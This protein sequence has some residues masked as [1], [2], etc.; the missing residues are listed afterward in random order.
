VFPALRTAVVASDGVDQTIPNCSLTRDFHPSSNKQSH[1]RQGPPLAGLVLYAPANCSLTR[2]FGTPFL[3][4][5]PSA[6]R[7]PSAN[8]SCAPSTESER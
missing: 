7:L 4:S 8:F 6:G 2:I 3:P 5:A 1:K